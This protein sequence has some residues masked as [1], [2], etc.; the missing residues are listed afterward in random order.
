MDWT[1]KE[2]DGQEGVGCVIKVGGW[3]V[4]G[5]LYLPIVLFWILMSPRSANHK[6]I[7][8]PRSPRRFLT[9][10]R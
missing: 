7:D 1:Y 2:V 5:R 6:P 8:K 10:T 3:A 4:G 9:S